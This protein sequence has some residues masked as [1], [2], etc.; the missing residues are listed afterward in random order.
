[1]RRATIRKLACAGMVLGIVGIG[2]M[3]QDIFNVHPKTIA[4]KNAV[5]VQ[6]EACLRAFKK[7]VLLEDCKAF[8]TSQDKKESGPAK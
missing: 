1:M 6:K 7:G 3:Y 4:Y 8:S 2:A 5:S